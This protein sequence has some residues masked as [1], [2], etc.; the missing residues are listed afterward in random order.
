MEIGC[1]FSLSVTEIHFSIFKHC[2]SSPGIVPLP[3]E[4]K[5]SVK[6]HIFPQILIASNP[7]MFDELFS[8]TL[9]Q[10]DTGTSPSTPTVQLNVF[11]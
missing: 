6:S 1:Q 9:K 5:E 10:K 2:L 11:A 8:T 7:G 4:V 3:A